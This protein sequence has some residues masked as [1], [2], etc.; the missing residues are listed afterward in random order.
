MAFYLVV[1]KIIATFASVK[2][3]ILLI[4]TTALRSTVKR[5]FMTK[6][7][8]INGRTFAVKSHVSD[9]NCYMLFALPSPDAHPND[10]GSVLLIDDTAC[11]DYYGDID[12]VSDIMKEAIRE[13]AEKPYPW[14]V[15]MDSVFEFGCA[16]RVI[17]DENDARSIADI[18]A[19]A[20]IS[21]VDMNNEEAVDAA[22]VRLGLEDNDVDMIHT[23]VSNG[24]CGSFSLVDE[25]Y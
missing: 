8:E 15:L 20:S 14:W 25:W 2:E 9:E 22:K 1:S 11:E 16:P 12:T 17:A 4:I 3:T 13:D 5:Y 18:L 24:S 19:C 7:F 6:E 21:E 10:Y 23:F